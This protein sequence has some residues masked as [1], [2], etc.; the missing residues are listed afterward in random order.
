M[1]Y[2]QPLEISDKDG[3]PTGKFHYTKRNGEHIYPVGYCNFRMKDLGEIIEKDGFKFIKTESGIEIPIRQEEINI[4]KAVE[5]KYHKEGHDTPEEACEC[6]KEY[7]LDKHMN[8]GHKMMGTKK[9]CENEGCEE[10][11]DNMAIVGGRSFILCDK[12]RNRET[13]EKMFEVGNAISSY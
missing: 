1:N 8:L 5:H 4:H 3:N 10:M 7:L 12:H 6:Y 9:T 2:Y 11:T 13:I